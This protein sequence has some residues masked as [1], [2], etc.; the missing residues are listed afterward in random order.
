M[1]TPTLEQAAG[2]RQQGN[3]CPVYREIL[4]DMETPVSAFLKI[5]GDKPYAFLL[6]SVENGTH[7]ARYSFIGADPYMTLR[8]D[9]GQALATQGGYKQRLPFDDPLLVLDSYLNTYRPVRLPGLPIFVGGAVGYL[10][11]EC[12]RYFER[13]P[14]APER[15]YAMPDSWWMF[16]DTLLVFDHVKHT[17]MVVSHIHLDAEDLGAEY[18]RAGARIEELIGRLSVPLPQAYAP[19]AISAG[20]ATEP[21]SNMTQEQFEAGVLIAQIGRAHV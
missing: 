5:A 10:S 6:E 21:A 2:L 1:Y 18:E 8:L 4:A 13:L 17:I 3:L 19:A 9:N 12:A 7:M 14:V 16:V 11:Y 15:A 20:Q